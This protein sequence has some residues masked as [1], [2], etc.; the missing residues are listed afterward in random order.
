MTEK[1]KAL[2]KKKRDDVY[3]KILTFYNSKN[4]TNRKT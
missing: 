2:K 1:Q 4:Y 3:I